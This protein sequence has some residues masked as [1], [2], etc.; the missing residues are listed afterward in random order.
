MSIKTLLQD[1]LDLIYDELYD[2]KAT[3]KDKE[4]SVFYAKDYEVQ[5]SKERVITAKSKD[6]IGINN[7]DTVTIGT[8]DYRVISFYNEP[9]GLET[10]I[11]LEK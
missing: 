7:S 3:Y 5:S 2:D 6:V 11:G 10:T 8:I 1:D 4:I 9:D